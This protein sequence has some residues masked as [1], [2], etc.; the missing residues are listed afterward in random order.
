M[1]MT[2]S[3]HNH[4]SGKWLHLKG[5]SLIFYFHD[6]GRRGS[7]TYNRYTSIMCRYIYVLYVQYALNQ[8]ELLLI[9]LFFH[10][11]LQVLF[12]LFLF[13][14]FVILLICTL[15][16]ISLNTLQPPSDFQRHLDELKQHLSP[17][18]GAGIHIEEVDVLHMW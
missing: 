9:K 3:P 12:S 10:S 14:C 7:T 13:C 4:G 8:H 6:Y 18:N 17:G 1:C 16:S 2:L 11:S 5:N 15:R